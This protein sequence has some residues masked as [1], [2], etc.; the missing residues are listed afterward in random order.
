MKKNKIN[1]GL[2]ILSLLS[3]VFYASSLESM[4]RYKKEIAAGILGA[5]AFR[6]KEK[7][8]KELATVGKKL[9]N[10][11][12]YIK[13]KWNRL[14]PEQQEQVLNDKKKALDQKDILLKK[15]QAIIKKM[16]QNYY[17]PVRLEEEARMEKWRKDR[18]DQILKEKKSAFNKEYPAKSIN[19][20]TEAEDALWHDTSAIDKS[21][22]RYN[23]Y[24][25]IYK[26]NPEKVKEL[27]EKFLK[28]KSITIIL[29]KAQEGM[30]SLKTKIA[31]AEIE[32]KDALTELNNLQKESNSF[33]FFWQKGSEGISH[34][35]LNEA[36]NKVKRA[37]E[38]LET[39]ER[40]LQ[41]KV[42]T[43]AQ[44]IEKKSPGLIKKYG[45]DILGYVITGLL[46]SY[47]TMNASASS[48]PS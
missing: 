40:K 34:D 11:G 32:F 12:T 42:K 36:K 16:E 25:D 30:I 20:I 38:N 9:S 45:K 1:T 4:S 44:S 24:E 17:K 8:A 47:V 27:Q 33:R 3:V 6:N 13:S 31:M 23:E 37:Q 41:E 43:A 18:Y 19:K 48:Q 15:E 22:G 5:L 10:I 21:E 35:E 46:V 39:L 26:M 14:T 28:E 29:K 2:R 7:I